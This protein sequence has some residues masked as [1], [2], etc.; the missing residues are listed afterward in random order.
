MHLT[1][2]TYIIIFFFSLIGSALSI[3]YLINYL[4]YSKIVDKPGERRINKKTIPRMGGILIFVAVNI[5]I[6]VFYKHINFARPV[7]ISSTVIALLGIWDDV[8]GLKY[9][10]KLVFQYAAALILLAFFRPLFNSTEIFGLV[11]PYPLNYIIILLFIVGAI[12]SVNLMDGLDGLVSGFAIQVF[13]VIIILSYISPN[14]F[15]LVISS[16]LLGSILGFL[17]FNAFPAKIFL[18]DTGSLYIGLF[19]VFTAIYTA[20]DFGKGTFDLTFPIILLGVP[21]VDTLKV[22]FVRLKGRKNPFHPDQNH[23]HHIIINGSFRHKTT[24]GFILF[25]SSLFAMDSLIYLKLY[26]TAGIVIFILLGCSLLLMQYILPT[27]L[28][29]NALIITR[30]KIINLT[31]KKVKLFY[32]FFLPASLISVMFLIFFLFPFSSKLSTEEL[33]VILFSVIGMLIVS[34]VRRQNDYL[35][36]IYVFFNIAIFFIIANF[37]S[38]FFSGN[39]LSQNIVKYL[40][41]G[42]LI[43]LS[44]MFVS[45]M[46]QWDKLNKNGK[47]FLSGLDITLIILLISLYFFNIIVPSHRF[48]FIEIN[49]WETIIV[50]LWYKMIVYFDNRF[51]K[52]V[53]YLSY[54]L[55]SL[56][57]LSI[58]IF[59]AR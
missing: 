42:A 38:S 7:I 54:A 59:S 56:A 26:K 51:S 19:L 13:W 49:F 9:I 53:Y 12:N 39:Y 52:T 31:E 3:P 58:L 44:L 45:F 55:P 25:I 40:M 8:R 48:H 23:L 5:A 29:F 20:V 35:K 21:I 37:S 16:A 28:N 11:L 47:V 2:S 18:G 24:V 27:I 14:P 36:D 34:L 17:K 10:Y 33:K 46:F 1:S 15:L 43:S 4:T 30:K 41:Y 57:I 32:Q 6:F 22:I 50:F